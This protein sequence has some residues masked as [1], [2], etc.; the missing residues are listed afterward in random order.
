[1]NEFRIVAVLENLF[2]GTPTR[3]ILGHS[4]GPRFHP[5]IS[6]TGQPHRCLDGHLNCAL[7]GRF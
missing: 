3:L 4:H 5:G 2:A 6:L 7:A 1:M